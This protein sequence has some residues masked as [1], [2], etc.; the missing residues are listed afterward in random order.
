MFYIHIVITIVIIITIVMAFL[1]STVLFCS[2]KIQDLIVYLLKY[3]IY[4]T[5]FYSTRH[6]SRYVLAYGFIIFPYIGR[7]YN[8]RN[9]LY[10][11]ED[12]DSM[13]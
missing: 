3:R 11:S 10:S 7:N 13:V 4:A 9:A 1:Q 5:C 8:L 12:F 2:N 6:I